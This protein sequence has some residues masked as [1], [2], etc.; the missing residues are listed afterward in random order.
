MKNLQKW[1]CAVVVSA[2]VAALGS[3]CQQSKITASASEV[4]VAQ[5]HRVL[6]WGLRRQTEAVWKPAELAWA[7]MNVDFTV[8]GDTY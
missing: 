2:G 3:A 7:D 8:K 1:R 4:L 5:G 6:L